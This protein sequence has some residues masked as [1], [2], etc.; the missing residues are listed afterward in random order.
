MRYKKDDVVK[1]EAKVSEV[2][3]DGYLVYIEPVGTFGWGQLVR[4]LDK[5]V[6]GKGKQK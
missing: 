3:E 6:L 5:Q 4:V 1:I 2:Y